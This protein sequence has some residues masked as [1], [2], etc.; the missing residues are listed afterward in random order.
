LLFLAY[1]WMAPP[2]DELNGS[3]MRI[4][5]LPRMLLSSIQRFSSYYMCS[6]I[7]RS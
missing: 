5:E 7:M 3:K 1:S 6:S 4:S 2:T